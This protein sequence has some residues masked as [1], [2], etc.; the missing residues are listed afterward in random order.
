MNDFYD[1]MQ[2]PHP[3]VDE[4]R[5]L[6]KYR[7]LVSQ[8]IIS[9]IKTR[10]KRSFLGVIWT[11]LN[12][13]LTMIVLT[14]VFSELWGAQTES[15]PVYILSGLIAWNLFSQST[16]EAMGSMIQKSGL[17]SRVYVPKSI[18]AVSAV[19]AG[20]VNLGLSLIPLIIIALVLST[21]LQLSILVTPFSVLLLALFSL[22]IGLILATAAV[23]FADMVPVYSVILTIWFYAT[24][25]IYPISILPPEWQKLFLLNPLY[26]LT[27]IFRQPIYEGT[28]PDPVTWTAAILSALVAFIIGGLLFTA[29]SHEYAYRT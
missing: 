15:Y 5:M 13:L 14:I 12:P 20:L 8:F 18:F 4:V 3:L 19:G 26:Y 16:T 10:Y 2:R 9:S 25:I 1:S 6:I 22:G 23:Y 29:K 24:P 27:Q 21:R 17:L 7:D 28:L 11:L